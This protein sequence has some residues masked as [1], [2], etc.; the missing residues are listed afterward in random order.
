MTYDPNGFTIIEEAR[1]PLWAVPDLDTL[2]PRNVDVSEA[3]RT[4]YGKSIRAFMRFLKDSGRT[5]YD[6]GDVL[7]YK[8]FMEASGLSSSTVSIRIASLRVLYDYLGM[9]EIMRKVHGGKQQRGFKKDALTIEEGRRLLGSIKGDRPEDVRDRAMVTL[10]LHTAL[11]AVEVSRADIGDLR[12]V[13]GQRVLYVQ[14]K[15]RTEKDDYVVLTDPV[16]RVLSEYLKGRDDP[17]L[18]DTPFFIS[19]SDR[20][21]GGRLHEGSVS[22][23][24]KK[25]MTD[26]GLVSPYLSCHSTRHSA[27]TWALEAGCPLQDVRAMARHANI[28]TTLIYDHSV[29]R[30]ANAPE[31]RIT[32]VLGD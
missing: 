4:T 7:E 23:I 9:P 18:Y 29:H 21:L 24:V 28:Q 13:S 1:P 20:S 8:R 2:A 26:A 10:M 30:V 32:A 11:R 16:M 19:Y 14:G 12:T 25:R 6:R 17:L 27:I 3:S 5:G 15:G 22:E 31:N